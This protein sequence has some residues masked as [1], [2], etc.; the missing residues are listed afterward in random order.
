MPAAI[1]L[2]EVEGVAGIIVAADAAVKAAEVELLGWDSIGGFTTVLFSGS[3]SDVGAALSSGTEA[4][5]QVV[6]HV[7][8]APVTQPSEACLSFVSNPVQKDVLVRSGALGLIETHGYAAHVC[9]DDEMVKTAAVDVVG[10]LT[11][12]NRVVCSLIQ[13]DVGAVREAVARAQT[14]LQGYPHLM[15]TVVLPQPHPEVLQAFVAPSQGA[16]SV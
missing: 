4:A 8:S 5:R 14:R 12:H 9:A 2:I 1:G 10:V 6:E 16:S 11:V 15:S 3:I 7:V 13:G